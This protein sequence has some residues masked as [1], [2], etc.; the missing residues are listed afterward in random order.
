M[1]YSVVTEPAF[2]CTV[3]LSDHELTNTLNRPARATLFDVC[4]VFV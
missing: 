3:I 1:V 4:F 2:I